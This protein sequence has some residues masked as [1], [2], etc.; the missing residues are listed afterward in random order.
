MKNAIASVTGKTVDIVAK[1][2]GLNSL[3]SVK[4]LIDGIKS[5]TVNV[6]TNVVKRISGA[7]KNGIGGGVATG[8]AHISHAIG[9]AYASGTAYDM[10]EDYRHSKNAWAKGTPQDWELPQDE[11]ALVNEVGTESIVRD[12]R[13]F[14][15]PGNAHVEQLKR[16]DILFSAK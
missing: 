4:R 16:G 9:T 3:D 7:I 5:K 15:I 8:T 13:W 10:W 1:V 14:E 11:E 12:G 6:V 2:T